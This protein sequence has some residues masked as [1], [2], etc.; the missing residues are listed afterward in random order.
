MKRLFIDFFI[1]D[2]RQT[3]SLYL[4]GTFYCNTTIIT[5]S[6]ISK[7]IRKLKQIFRCRYKNQYH[8]HLYHYRCSPQGCA[9]T[10]ISVTGTQLD[11]SYVTRTRP[12]APCH[13]ATHRSF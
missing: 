3:I 10:K 4:Y 12:H 13:Y 2:M 8:R 9:G 7:I 1:H 5:A 11:L 6:G